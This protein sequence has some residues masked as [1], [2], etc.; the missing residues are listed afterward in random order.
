MTGQPPN[1]APNVF[2][3]P[4]YQRGISTSSNVLPRGIGGT[5]TANDLGSSNA[6]HGAVD[7]SHMK[8]KPNFF[9]EGRVLA[10]V[11]NET[12]GTN[13]TDYNTSK[14]Y[15]N[16][17]VQKNINS[18]L[19]TDNY[20]YTEQRRFVV[21]RRMPEFCYACPIFTYG[22]QGTLK[23]GVRAEQHAVAYSTSQ[24]AQAFKD[25]IGKITKR[26]IGVVMESG[27]PDLHIASRIYFG[28]HH[29]IQYNVRVKNIGR[30]REKDMPNLI[31][32]WKEEDKRND[33]VRQSPQEASGQLSGGGDVDE[34][35]YD[36]KMNIAGYHPK[37]NP[38]SFHP[39]HNPHGF[40]HEKT[41]YCYH[42][43]FNPYGYHS[44]L[45]KE[46]YH[47]VSNLQGYHPSQNPNC[48]H[49]IMNPYG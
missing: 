28:I 41:P 35:T 5:I 33:E 39:E 34:F 23:K 42:E 3:P 46:A 19:Y 1:Y 49:E 10:V 7:P 25:E 26:P 43:K 27:E 4:Q 8:R 9:C 40:H 32:Y 12:A 21:V 38:H 36:P 24:E 37:L 20:V 16:Q 18:V 14:S 6:P 22:G 17:R 29:P 45:N 11:W 13:A 48:Y 2:P 30:V 31:G 15:N 44:T 47:P